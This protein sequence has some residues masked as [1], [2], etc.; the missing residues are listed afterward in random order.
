M[1][2]HGKPRAVVTDA[3]LR[4]AVTIARS[5]GRAG[6]NVIAAE[7][8]DT[9]GPLAFH[10]K[11]VGSGLILSK[12]AKTVPSDR[13]L[14]ALLEAAGHD[15]VLVPVFTPWVVKMSAD[16]DKISG[17]ANTLVPPMESL[18]EAH[19][20][21]RCTKLAQ[22]LGVPIPR[23]SVPT[24]DGVDVA[25]AS[26]MLHWARNLP[27]P[28][29]LK[30]RSG[31][32]VGLPASLRYRVCRNPEET[33]AAYGQMAIVQS[34]PLAQE[35]VVGDDCGVALLYDGESRPVAS[36]T[37]RSIRERPKGAGPT[38]YA[39]SEDYPEMLDYSH[40]ILSA[41]KW[42]GMAMLD[43]KRG[44][45]GT[46]R[47]LEVNPRFWGSLALSVEAGVDFPLLYYRSCLG[48]KIE[49]VRQRN[50]VKV[51]FFPGD[52]LSLLEYAKV[53]GNGVRYVAKGVWDLLRSGSKDGL[54]TLSDPKPGLIHLAG[55]VFSRHARP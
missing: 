49:P 1:T 51:R 9:A 24:E 27:Y 35:Y 37:Y 16:A 18:R 23:T 14:E 10:S 26:S 30:Y 54:F 52:F 43:F 3:R 36:F 12:D 2:F 45:D 33:V 42:R 40:R 46:F 55:G 5:L 28:V 4:I 11:F 15:G 50:G 44:A 41:L 22:N 39:V 25:D 21:T 38:V 19:D 17:R 7:A 6:V 20:K 32:D 47:F 13:D 29:I 48:E 34:A 8:A 53:P 31:E